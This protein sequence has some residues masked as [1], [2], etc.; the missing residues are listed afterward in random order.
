MGLE[1]LIKKKNIE[2]S[3]S[4]KFCCVF[5]FFWKNNNNKQDHCNFH[6]Q[7]NIHFEINKQTV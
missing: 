7:W 2:T 1:Q 4:M 3:A 6:G 5:S